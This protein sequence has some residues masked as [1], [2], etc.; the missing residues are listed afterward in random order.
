MYFFVCIYRKVLVAPSHR[1]ATIIVENI[2]KHFFLESPGRQGRGGEE[3]DE[4]SC[5]ELFHCLQIQCNIRMAPESLVEHRSALDLQ[6][7]HR[8]QRKLQSGNEMPLDFET[9]VTHLSR[10]G[11]IIARTIPLSH[12]FSAQKR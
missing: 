4:E 5:S 9:I 10:K 2:G 3:N 12:G 6:G 8:I 7:N 1:G 11:N